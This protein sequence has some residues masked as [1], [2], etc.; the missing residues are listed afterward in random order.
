[1]FLFVAVEALMENR[2]NAVLAEAAANGKWRAENGR[3][4]RICVDRRKAM[5]GEDQIGDEGEA[6]YTWP[7]VTAF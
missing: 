6:P 2:E 7:R 5:A 1:M 3:I 4:T